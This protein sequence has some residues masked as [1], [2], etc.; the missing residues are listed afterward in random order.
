VTVEQSSGSL[1]RSRCR[2]AVARTSGGRA[3]LKLRTRRRKRSVA[4]LTF[5]EAT[6]S[7]ASNPSRHES[8]RPDSESEVLVADV[9]DDFDPTPLAGAIGVL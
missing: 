2:V 9:A 6:D 3:P 7:H 8:Q 5:F 4:P 1:R